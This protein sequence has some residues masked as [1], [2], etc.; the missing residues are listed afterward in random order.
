[1]SFHILYVGAKWCGACKTIKPAVEQL[2][3]RYAIELKS[4]DYDDDLS[5]AEKEKI[6]KVPTVT[7]VQGDRNIAQWNANQVVNLEAYL[8]ANVKLAATDDF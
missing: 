7:I 5:E 8:A 3:K 6:T 4:L 2:A 1:M